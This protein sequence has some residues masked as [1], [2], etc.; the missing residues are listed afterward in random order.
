MPL[1]YFFEGDASVFRE[2]PDTQEIMIDAVRQGKTAFTV[3]FSKVE[4]DLGKVDYVLFDGR[5]RMV[6]H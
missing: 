4:N 6:L 5:F 2:A 3:Y 1:K